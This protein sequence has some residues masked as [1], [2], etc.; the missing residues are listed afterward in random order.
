MVHAARDR[1]GDLR[2]PLL[3]SLLGLAAVAAVADVAVVLPG[4]SHAA[5]KP[6]L[7]R[8]FPAGGQAG[9]AV[10]VEAIGKFP[11]WPV[12]AWSDT[13]SIRWSFQEG[14]GKL[15][16]TIDANATPGLHWVRLYHPHGATTV[17]PFL[18]GHSPE[19]V[20]V[21]PNNRLA[22][23]N[24]IASVPKAVNGV[25]SKRGEVDIFSLMLCAGQRIVAT[26]DAEQGLRSPLDASLQ[27][28]DA[29]G[30]VLKENLDH[31][32][33]DPSLAFTAPRDGKYAMR[34]FG[35]P[36][37]PDQTIAFGGGDAWNYRL[38]IQSHDEP[39]AFAPQRFD[40]PIQNLESNQA[41]SKETALLLKIPTVVTGALDQ[42]G[43][44]RFLRFQAIAGQQ[45]RMRLFARN[46]GS[47]LDATLSVLDSQGKQLVLQDDAGND[48]DPDLKWKAPADGEFFI[49]IQDFHKSGGEHFD[50]EL[51]MSAMMP[52]FKLSVA[53]DLIQTT[54]GKETELE[55]AI[56]RECD[57]A[58]EISV[59][60]EG[61]EG[62]IECPPVLS[63]FGKETA[64][65][66]TL[67]IKNSAPFQGPVKVSA[68]AAELPEQVRWAT[69]ESE[70][71][72]WLSAVAE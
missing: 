51:A 26:V 18:I 17:R 10:D 67:R 46:H 6:E 59:S 55:V 37:T 45:Y 69:T 72:I 19:Q 9:T 23:A 34:V 13:D 16:A 44:H 35:F 2:F 68:K 47:V 58:G 1:R 33:L 32:G 65:K 61:V 43:Q 36:A 64:K 42:R 3:H 5:D 4:Q 28:L 12:Q 20:E 7:T 60:L 48:R 40:C 63:V 22:D 29:N 14:S 50:F 27:L 31:F 24:I 15:K 39:F 30:F 57:F 49:D 38:R 70:K 66:V 25:L 52:D 54:V 71:P 62:N 41:T 53:N 21:E 8:L 56:V 11:V